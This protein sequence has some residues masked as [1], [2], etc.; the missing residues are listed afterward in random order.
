MSMRYVSNTATNNAMLSWANRE[1]QRL[2][3]L[4]TNELNNV[5]WLEE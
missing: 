3:A 2:S 1:V 4:P 5:S